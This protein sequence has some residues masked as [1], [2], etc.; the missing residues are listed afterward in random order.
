MPGMVEIDVCAHKKIAKGKRTRWRATREAQVRV[1]QMRR[2]RYVTRLI[3]LNF[4]H[5]SV[6]LELDYDPGHYTDSM[7]EAKREIR[8]YI[9]RIKRLYEKMIAEERTLRGDKERDTEEFGYVYTTERGEESGRVHHH[10]IVKGGL[11]K[12]QLLGAWGKSKRCQ[13]EYLEFSENGYT[14]LACYYAKRNEPF[15]RCFTC[16]QNLIRPE[17]LPE[18][19]RE[20]RRLSR[21]FTKK[22][23]RDFYEHNFTRA[24]MAAMFPGY[25]LC[26]GWTCSYNPYDHSYYMHMRLLK[27]DADIASWATTV[28]YN[29]GTPGDEYP[30]DILRPEE[31]TATKA[32][33]QYYS[34][35]E[36]MM[37]EREDYGESE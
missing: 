6:M 20:C 31:S 33:Q 22:N 35:Y 15:E 37:R 4:D 1:N 36:R 27:P 34:A 5:R 16:S 8:N 28:T 9:R 29:A 7:E 24:E 10:L 2:K 13:A 17:P 30:W 19:D 12:E 11:T 21:V 3:N 23:C 26:D 18:E 25:K 14:D 32:E